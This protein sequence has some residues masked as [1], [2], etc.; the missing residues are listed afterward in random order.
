MLKVY[1]KVMKTKE[2]ILFSPTKKSISWKTPGK[3]L[4]TV[5]IKVS[6]VVSKEPKV[7]SSTSLDEMFFLKQLESLG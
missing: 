1:V 4:E 2:T 5:A 7:S 6:A 3:T